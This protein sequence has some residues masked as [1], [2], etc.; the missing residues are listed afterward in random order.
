MTQSQWDL[1]KTDFVENEN[2]PAHFRASAAQFVGSWS[3]RPASHRNRNTTVELLHPG[4]EIIASS[5]VED[6]SRT[7]FYEPHITLGYRRDLGPNNFSLKS[8]LVDMDEKIRGFICDFTAPLVYTGVPTAE[9]K[10]LLDRRDVG[11]MFCDCCGK[12]LEELQLP[13]FQRCARCLMVFYCSPACQKEHWKKKGHKL[14]CRENGQIEIGDDMHLLKQQPSGRTIFEFV[15]VI[16][17]VAGDRWQVKHY[18]SGIIV[19]VNAA[20]L[21]RLRPASTL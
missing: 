7:V 2:E 18:G 19:T 14:S 15:K 17:S 20:N 6:E 5:P 16:A 21:I 8:I 3:R 13:S 11:G 10:L 4:L 12:T 1:F 9:E